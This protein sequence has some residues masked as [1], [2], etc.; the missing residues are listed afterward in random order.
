MSMREPTVFDG[1]CSRTAG[2]RDTGEEYGVITVYVSVRMA[3]R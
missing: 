1:E 3:I 2:V